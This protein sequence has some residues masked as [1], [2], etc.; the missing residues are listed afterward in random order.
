MT[1]VA[2]CT[3]SRHG[4]TAAY[5]H[6]GC[7]CPDAKRASNRYDKV[8]R[9]RKARGVTAP[10]ASVDAT[11]TRRRL[12]ALMATGW[13][14]EHLADRLGVTPPA[15]RQWCNR[16]Q[17][18]PSTVATVRALY[19]ELWRVPGPSE[20]ARRRAAARGYLPPL[21]WDDDRIDDPAYDPRRDVVS[22]AQLRDEARWERIERVARLTRAGWSL[23]QI[24]QELDKHPR[25]V[26]RDLEDY[27]ER[28]GVQQLRIATVTEEPY[29]EAPA[30]HPLDLEAV[31]S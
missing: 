23:T 21:W 18:K 14:Y 17:V 1:I 6:D 11:G 25:Q 29:D 8:K 26:S 3:A 16:E 9:L 22:K 27:R 19:E 28:Y 24:A 30:C 5:N 31:A 2:V 15:V 10:H 12:H 7:R 20:H 13:S 4:T